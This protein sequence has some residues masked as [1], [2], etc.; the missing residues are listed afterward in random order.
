ML[1]GDV[2][3]SEDG[4][5]FA[6]LH[7]DGCSLAVHRVGKSEPLWETGAVDIQEVDES[8]CRVTLQPNGNLVILAGPYVVWSSNTATGEAA[9]RQQRQQFSLYEPARFAVVDDDGQLM[10]LEVLRSSAEPVCLWSSRSC[11]GQNPWADLWRAVK[12][13][14][15]TILCHVVG[16]EDDE[17]EYDQDDSDAP[18]GHAHSQ[19]KE[20]LRRAKEVGASAWHKLRDVLN[21]GN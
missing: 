3:H 10:V 5:H 14:S 4:S 6:V 16:C 2:L 19:L 12:S 8:E 9:Q 15:T 21:K 20:G 17:F 11:P 1:I 18:Q 7:E 13:V